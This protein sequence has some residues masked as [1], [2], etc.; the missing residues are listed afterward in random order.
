MEQLWELAKDLG[1]EIQRDPRFIRTQMAQAKADEDKE[2][3]DLIGEFNLKRMAINT[4]SAKD[5]SEQDKDKLLQLNAEI[6]EVY[7]R[8]MANDSMAEYQAAKGELD[9]IINGIGAII[10]MAA[11][12]LNPDEYEEH[13]CSGN[14]SSCGGCH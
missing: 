11:Q 2:L 6:R 3:Q 8:V 14:C 10:N 5:E 9:R 12:G 7:A 1:H 4:E 13:N